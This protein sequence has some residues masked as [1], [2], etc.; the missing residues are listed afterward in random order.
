MKILITDDNESK[1]LAV[2]NGVNHVKASPRNLIYASQWEEDIQDD[3]LLLFRGKCSWFPWN[4]DVHKKLIMQPLNCKISLMSVMIE[5]AD[6]FCG[7][8]DMHENAFK[9]NECLF[10]SDKLVSIIEEI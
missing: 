9:G 7:F 8:C 4:N 2:L 3:P 10:A 6:N 5:N 1:K